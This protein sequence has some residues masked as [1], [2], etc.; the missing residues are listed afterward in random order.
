[1]QFP[2]RRPFSLILAVQSIPFQNIT[3]PDP[4]DLPIKLMQMDKSS[5]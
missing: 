2:F 1:M 5:R 4:L 3:D